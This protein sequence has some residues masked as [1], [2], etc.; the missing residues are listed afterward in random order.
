[1]TGGKPRPYVLAIVRTKQTARS[2]WLPVLA[3][4]AGGC[5]APGAEPGTP[6]DDPA[7]AAERLKARSTVEAPALVRFRWEYA[8]RQGRLSGEGVARVN[9]PDHFRLDLFS[10]AEGSMAASLVDGDLVTLGQ[11]EDVEL[12]PPG[13]LYAMAGVFRPGPW[14]PSAGYR[15][16]EDEVLEYRVDDRLRRYRFRAGRLLAVEE[17]EGRRSLRRIESRWDAE[18]PWPA[19]AE[20]EDRIAPSRVRWELVESRTAEEPFPDDIYDLDGTP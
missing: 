9:P 15:S 2:T 16:G 4:L 14:N 19:A 10:S 3:V 1:M 5:A 13:F 17:S 11:I 18:G 7:V 8:D 20:Y 12:P 6:M